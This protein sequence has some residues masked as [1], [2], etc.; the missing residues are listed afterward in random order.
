MTAENGRTMRI[1][2]GDG[3]SPEVFTSIAGAREDSFSTEVGEIDITDKDSAAYREL[4]AGGIKSASLSVSGVAKNK[5][6]LMSLVGVIQNYQ[7]EWA[8]GDVLAGAFQLGS[9]SFTGSHENSAVTFTAELRSS[10]T[11]TFTEA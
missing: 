5:G 8:D 7:L 2:A 11:F 3:A 4:L 6:Q 9:L 1:K 10:G